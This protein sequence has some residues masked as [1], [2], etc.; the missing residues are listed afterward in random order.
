VLAWKQRALVVH[1]TG[2]DG[3]REEPVQHAL[4]EGLAAPC[5]A[6]LSCPPLRLPAAPFQILEDWQHGAQFEVLIEDGPHLVCFVRI[7]DET[8]RLDVNVVAEDRVAA[9]PLA[10]LTRGT[11][12]VASPL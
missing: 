2:V 12:L 9:D 11:H 4:R 7:H 1:L 5:L 10:L 8:A 6:G 3:V